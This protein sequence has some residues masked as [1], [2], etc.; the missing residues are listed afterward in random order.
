[1]GN[2]HFGYF[3]YSVA[4]HGCQKASSDLDQIEDLSEAQ[5][6]QAC[7]DH[8]AN[9]DGPTLPMMNVR[10]GECRMIKWAE[11]RPMGRCMIKRSRAGVF[12]RPSATPSPLPCVLM[13]GIVMR[14]SITGP[15]TLDWLCV[16]R[17]LFVL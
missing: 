13:I 10:I 1:M 5:C 8:R 17:M 12:S 2:L 6:I 14:T 3:G 4:M 11:P 7:N 16:G 15:S 9:F